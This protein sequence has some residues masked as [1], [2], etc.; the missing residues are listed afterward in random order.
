MLALIADYDCKTQAEDYLREV[1]VMKY[2]GG[3]FRQSSARIEEYLDSRIGESPSIAPPS[4]AVSVVGRKIVNVEVH[5]D[6]T[7]RNCLGYKTREQGPME[8]VERYIEML[9]TKRETDCIQKFC[10]SDPEED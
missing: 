8:Q 7:G 3:I 6:D 1:E 10:E 2:L 4:T 9:P 5:L